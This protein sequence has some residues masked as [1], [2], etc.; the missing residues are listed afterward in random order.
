[1]S[2]KR[3][4]M[5]LFQAINRQ[6]CHTSIHSRVHPLE[7]RDSTNSLSIFIRGTMLS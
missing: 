7:I 2:R 3:I 4:T 1:M 5:G 6:F